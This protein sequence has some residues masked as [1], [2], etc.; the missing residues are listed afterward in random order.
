MADGYW[1]VTKTFLWVEKVYD[2]L[3]KTTI[4]KAKVDNYE[5]VHTWFWGWLFVRKNIFNDYYEFVEG[6]CKEFEIGNSWNLRY[7]REGLAKM[8]FDNLKTNNN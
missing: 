3:Y 1:A 5:F 6:K 7:N 8:Y 2:E 4:E